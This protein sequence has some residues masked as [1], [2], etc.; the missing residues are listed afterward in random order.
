MF[1]V[2]YSGVPFKPH[3]WTLAMSAAHTGR[4]VV[5]GMLADNVFTQCVFPCLLQVTCH[6]TPAHLAHA[7]PPA[8]VSGMTPGQSLG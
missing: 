1:H 5:F 4:Q 2:L 6:Y 3:C 7:M 8:E